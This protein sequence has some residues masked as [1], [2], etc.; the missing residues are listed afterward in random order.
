MDS[1][2]VTLQFVKDMMDTF[3]EQKNIHRRY[4]FQI[5]LHIRT[6]LKATP[7]L[8]DITVPDGKHFTVCGDIHG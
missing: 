6:M 3:K 2:K 8:V 5:L 1:D 4:A 7:T